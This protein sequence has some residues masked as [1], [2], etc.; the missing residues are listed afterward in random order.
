MNNTW[1]GRGLVA[2]VAIALIQYVVSSLHIDAIRDLDELR[3]FVL[4]ILMAA[5]VVVALV[6][7]YRRKRTM[8][9][10]GHDGS[11]SRE[12]IEINAA[13]YGSV[14]VAF[15]FF[16][17]WFTNFTSSAGFWTATLFVLI[18]GSTG[19]HLQRDAPSG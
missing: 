11:V 13:M 5:A 19:L 12:Y 8:D 16:M 14:V 6:V 15:W 2:V 10:N 3:W 9:E 7:N 1:I 4:N 18:V 17:G